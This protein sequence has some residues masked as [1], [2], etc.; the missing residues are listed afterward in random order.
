MLLFREQGL[1]GPR[2]GLCQVSE[3]HLTQVSDENQDKA[4]STEAP[5]GIESGHCEARPGQ[6][7]V[8]AT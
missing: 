5:W 7:D 1:S 4:Y 3:A 2:S 6:Q 8:L